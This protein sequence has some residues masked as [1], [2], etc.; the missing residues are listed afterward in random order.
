MVIEYPDKIWSEKTGI[1]CKRI[2]ERRRNRNKGKKRKKERR[3]K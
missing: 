1:P 3:K 2:K